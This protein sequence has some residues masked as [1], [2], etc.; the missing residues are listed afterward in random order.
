MTFDA[1][2]QECL[3]NVGDRPFFQCGEFA[4]V[5]SFI[6]AGEVK[7]VRFCVI[8]DDAKLKAACELLN[9]RYDWRGYGSSH[10]IPSGVHHTTFTAEV[11]G[12]IVGTLTL[13][14]DSANGLAVD[15]AFKNEVDHVRG[16]GDTQICELTR[17]AFHPG[18]RSKDVLAGL[19]H[20]AFIY[21]T[22]VT[23]C[24]DLLIEVNPRH[25]SFYEAM[26]G[27]QRVG[28]LKS[29]DKVSAP[30]QL[31]GLKVDAIVQNI[32]ERAGRAGQSHDRSLYPNFYPPEQEDQIRRSLVLNQK[33]RR[34][35]RDIQH[36][37]GVLAHET[38]DDAQRATSPTDFAPMV[39]DTAR[40]RARKPAAAARRAA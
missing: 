32:A 19:F 20:L 17:F 1:R 5:R 13:A 24:T 4:H 10:V 28:E 23:Q 2:L 16:A 18:I 7:D 29:N 22:T 3:S 12:E 8:E 40:R 25:V 9:S 37:Q 26:L 15:G 34:I 21:G 35:Q 14:V 36:V 38:T 33:M 6:I 11:D 27:F 31:L 39:L 30:A